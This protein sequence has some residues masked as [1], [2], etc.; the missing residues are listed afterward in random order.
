MNIKDGIVTADEK[1]GID[2]VLRHWSWVAA[3]GYI[4]TWCNPVTGEHLA[5]N[6]EGHRPDQLSYVGIQGTKQFVDAVFKYIKKHAT[7]IKN[8]SYGTRSYL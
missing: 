2:A 3:D 4:V 5:P 8:E 1:D 6:M 7:F